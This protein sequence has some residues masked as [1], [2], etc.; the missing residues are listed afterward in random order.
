MPLT[1]SGYKPRLPRLL[2]VLRCY[3]RSLFPPEFR[4]LPWFIP[5]ENSFENWPSLDISNTSKSPK[6]WMGPNPNEPRSVSWNCDRAIRYPGLGV[7][8]PW[9]PIWKFLGKHQT[10]R[11]S[12]PDVCNSQQHPHPY[13]PCMVRIFTYMKTHKNLPFMWMFPKIV[14]PPNHPF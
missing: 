6:K 9:G 1:F 14:V 12:L 3:P 13:H 10:F 5:I 4:G 7:R 8:G 2:G 11:R